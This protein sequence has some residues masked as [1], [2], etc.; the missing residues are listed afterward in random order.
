MARRKPKSKE[1]E[2]PPPEPKRR[3]ARW[4]AI[5][6]LL[7]LILSVGLVVGARLT[8][9][10]RIHNTRSPLADLTHDLQVA[11][12]K[13]TDGKTPGDMRSVIE[14][15]S[16]VVGRFLHY[17]QTHT[18]RLRFDAQP[19]EGNSIEYATLFA[20]VFNQLAR[21]A[22]LEAHAAVVHSDQALVFGRSLPFRGMGYHEWVLV[23]QKD[24]ARWFVD[25]L[26]ADYHLG[27]NLEGNVEGDVPKPW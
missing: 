23:E 19:R 9:K 17:G 8:L 4:I 7:V 5:A 11:I 15:S 14:L 20:S 12:Q 18:T 22:K 6:G 13:S 1:R 25:P 27:W 10:L 16:Q 24:G 3:S 21:W 2:A 26:L